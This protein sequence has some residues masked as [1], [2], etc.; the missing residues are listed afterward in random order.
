M[1]NPYHSSR[2]SGACNESWNHPRFSYVMVL[3]IGV[4][5]IYRDIPINGESLDL[6]FPLRRGG[7][8][9]SFSGEVL[10]HEQKGWVRWVGYFK[11]FMYILWWSGLLKI[12]CAVSVLSKFVGLVGQSDVF[13][14][15]LTKNV[16]VPDQIVRQKILEISIWWMKSKREI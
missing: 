15:C 13:Y 7:S 8:S 11:P 1:F 4:D 12:V 6:F 14:E 2:F 9:R 3:F 16:G 10:N 5:S